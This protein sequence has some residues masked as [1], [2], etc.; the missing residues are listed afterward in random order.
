MDLTKILKPGAKVYSLI[1]GEVEV[2]EITNEDYPICTKNKNGQISEYTKDGCYLA[3]QGECIL[4]PSKECRDWNDVKILELFPP[5]KGDYLITRDFHAEDKDKD[6]VFIFNGKSI[7]RVYGAFIGV[8]ILGKLSTIETNTWTTHAY[9][10]AT[11]E[12]I[13]EFDNRLLKERNLK[14]NKVTQEFEK[15]SDGEVYYYVTI[16]DRICV[17]ETQNKG[18]D[19]DNYRAKVLHNYFSTREEAEEFAKRIEDTFSVNINVIKE[20]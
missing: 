3:E 20:E 8:N 9:R 17:H 7:G 14:F 2:Y 19:E 5:Q 6:R 12:E 15:V 18:T 11:E 10:Y 16:D 1:H 4:F 13:E